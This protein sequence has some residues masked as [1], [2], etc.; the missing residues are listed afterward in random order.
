VK[1]TNLSGNTSEGW[2]NPKTAFVF[3]NNESAEHTIE[4]KMAEGDESKEFAILGFG[5]CP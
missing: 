3:N 5:V 1:T 4:I 2:G